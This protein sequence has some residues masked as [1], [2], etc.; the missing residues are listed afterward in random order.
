MKTKKLIK[1]AFES[2]EL[3]SSGELM[4]FNL[5]LSEKKKKKSAKISKDERE[6]S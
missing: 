2:P 6:N 4:Y 5:W 3:F 1:K